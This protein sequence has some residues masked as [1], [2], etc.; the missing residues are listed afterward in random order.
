MP[1][2][3]LSLLVSFAL[4][5]SCTR[6]PLPE[7]ALTTDGPPVDG[8]TFVEASLGDPTRLNPLLATDSASNTVNGYVFNGLVKYDR[9][10]KLVGDLAASWTVRRGGLEIVFKLRPN[11]RWHDGAPFTAADVV[12]TH[13]RLTDPKVLTPFGADFALVRSVEA[14]DPLTVRVT[15]KEPFAPA[16][17]SWGIGIVPR[18]VFA[19]GDFNAHPA[20]RKP[21]G[22]GPYRFV[23]LKTDEKAVLRA[24]PDYFE[25]RPRLDRVIVR[26]IPDSS[27]QFLELRNQS[28]DTMGL[29]PDQHIAYDAYFQNHQKFR[30]PSFSYTFLGFNL[31]RALVPGQAGPPRRGHGPGQARDHRRCPPGLRALRDGALPSFLLGFRSRRAGNSP[32]SRGGPRSLLAEAGWTDTDGDGV[33]DKDGRPFAFT[34]ITNQGNKL[35]EQTAV[36]LQSHLARLGVKMEVRVLEWSSFIHDFVDKGNFDAII[37]GWNLGRDP[38]QYLIWHSSQQGEG[39]YNFVGYENPL[40]DRLWE[41]GRRTFDRAARER[42]YRKIHR[43]LAEDLPYVFLYYPDSLP[44]VHKRFRNVEVAPAGL[45]WNFREW[46]VPKILQRYRL[47]DQ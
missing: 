46:Y 40:V 37:L 25:G 36:I 1:L 5:S 20:N 26:V 7:P 13:E 47:A 34:V 8:D 33:L 16:L 11:V 4:L 14:V 2:R 23:E 31:K 12:F 24:N 35:R 9:D 10:L 15:Y 42:V 28:I 43:V 30:Y 45:G 22:T 39:R 29:R 3:L 44:T 6:D 17:E 41:E 27:V 38:D 21:I 19:G 18:H 32:R